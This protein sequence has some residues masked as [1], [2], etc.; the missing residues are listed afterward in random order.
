V[1]TDS[2]AT[3]S[4]TK[5]RG[6]EEF[7]FARKASGLVRGLS[8][9]DAFLI[10]FMN[11]GIIVNLWYLT[12][13]GL[14]IFYGGNIV[15]A[16]VI[17][18]VLVGFSFPLIWGILGG[19]MPRSGGEYIY[20]S[21][22]I[23]PLVG[24][25][26]SWGNAWVWIF[27]IYILA[28][29]VNDVA[30]VGMA[31]QM[32]W[33]SLA[34]FSESMLGRQLVPLLVNVAAFLTIAFGIKIMAAIQKGVFVVTTLGAAVMMI[35]LTMYGREDMVARWDEIAAQHDSLAYADVVPAVEAAIG[36]ALPTTWNWYDTFGIMV[37]GSYLF[38]YAYCIT[39]IAGEVKRPD[40]TI[41]WSNFT[42]IIV[43][44]AFGIWLGLAMMKMF[45]Q[46][47]M[48]AVG[49][50]DLNWGIEGYNVPYTPSVMGL[51]FMLVPEA[52]FSIL[53]AAAYAGVC[54]WWVVLSY[55]ATPRIMFAW[56]LDRMGPNWFSD[57]N[58][59]FASP[60]K[61]YVAVFIISQ[62]LLFMYPFVGESM[63]TYTVSGLE[64]LTVFGIT[65]IAAVLLPYR[66][67]VKMIWESSPYRTWKFL[68]IPLVSIAGVVALFYL[69]FLFYYLIIRPEL[70]SITSL[71][72]VMYGVI[73]GTGLAWY[74]FWRQ[75][76]RSAGIDIR[77]TYGELPPE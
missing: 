48:A 61:N 71:S 2:P 41:I 1:P 22:I 47:F 75:R 13:L 43:P 31:Y 18:L 46:D 60:I 5:G 9:F 50:I 34:Q 12:T 52:W 25:L 56:G 54:Y 74:L 15:I 14:G 26:E 32:G 21:R 72:L 20:N 23:H 16:C 27:W 40:Q 35:V 24:V 59:R 8:F 73:Y 42:A 6:Q 70:R 55:L 57:V 7:A 17:S 33:D 64:W 69:A 76:S 44:A 28:P 62:I 11:Q 45:P 38:A 19:T 58:A 53:L 66:G 77:L 30:L 68:G 3:P 29:W 51:A 67:K 39:Y 10:G 63:Q 36:Q 65:A 4:T 49:Y 37:A